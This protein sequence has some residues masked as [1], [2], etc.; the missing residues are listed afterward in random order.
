[1]SSRDTQRRIKQAATKLFN[2]Y[3]T[4]KISTNTIAEYCEISKGNLHYHFKNKQEIIKAIYA[5][6]AT[7]IESDWSD[8]ESQPT[9]SHMAEMH[10]RQLELIWRYR[11]FY[12]EM[13]ALAKADPELADSIQLNR[14]KRIN[15][16]VRFFE[17]LIETGV[18]KKPRSKESLRYMVVMTWIFTDN[19]LNFMELQGNEDREEVA[20]LGYDMI[21]EIL[22][23]YLTDKAT[24]EIYDSYDALRQR[25]GD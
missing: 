18:L 8:D 2:D 12:R 7:E 25:L 9:V 22:Y 14:E 5:D 1:M 16:L 10:A 19:W 4:S 21:I 11:F 17:K 24:R 20:Q 3:G 13:A 15:I 23:P 6:I